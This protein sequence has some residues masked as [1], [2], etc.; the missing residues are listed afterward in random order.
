MVRVLKADS[1]ETPTMIPQRS[2]VSFSGTGVTNGAITRIIP[3]AAAFKSDEVGGENLI[4]LTRK[5]FDEEIRA[6]GLKR[7]KRAGAE[8]CAD[9]EG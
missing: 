6:Q 4:E 7:N 5:P 8:G 2:D 3:N 1:E 9:G